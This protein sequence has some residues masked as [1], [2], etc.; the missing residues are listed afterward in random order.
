VASNAKRI[1]AVADDGS[2]FGRSLKNVLRDQLGWKLNSLEARTS[3][4]N[5]ALHLTHVTGVVQRDW[6]D[7]KKVTTLQ[8]IAPLEWQ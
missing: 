2:W 3:C 6:L 1:A 8:Q 4:R 7:G 5:S